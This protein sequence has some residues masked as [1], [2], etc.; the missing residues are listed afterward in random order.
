ML[1]IPAFTTLN[2]MMN[3][4]SPITASSV[5]PMNMGVIHM[6]A[7]TMTAAMAAVPAPSPIIA[8]VFV[9]CL[10]YIMLDTSTS[11]DVAIMCMIM[12]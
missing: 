7:N 4:M 2:S 12:P 9:L 8:W 10:A 1:L 3:G 11:T 6:L 5:T